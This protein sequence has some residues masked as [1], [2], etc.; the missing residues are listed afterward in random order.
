MKPTSS[1]VHLYCDPDTLDSPRPLL[2]ADCEG[3]MGGDQEP[4]GSFLE[5]ASKY[6]K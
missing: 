3:L 5:K 6:F 4:A 1:D 2:F